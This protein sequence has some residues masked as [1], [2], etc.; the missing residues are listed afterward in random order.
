M[1]GS[2]CTILNNRIL[3]KDNFIDIESTAKRN[4]QK[5]EYSEVY[6]QL[7]PNTKLFYT[8][9]D[10]REHTAKIKTSIKFKES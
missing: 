5:N 9:S 2:M 8:V 4:C 3:C 1:L 7:L 10:V 6:N